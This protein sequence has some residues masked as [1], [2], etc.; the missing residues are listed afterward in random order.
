MKPQD[1]ASLHAAVFSKTARDP[2]WVGYWLAR[3]Q[4]TEDLDEDQ[5]AAKLGMT[6]DNLVLLCL[7]RTPRD[8]A[9]F[10]QDVDAICQ[11]TGVDRLVLKNLLRQEKNHLRWA[12]T[13]PPQA[14]GYLAAA[15]DAPPEPTDDQ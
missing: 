15:A 12:Q 5:L 8:G 6:M 3:H 4:Q 9:Q 2:D 14:G 11:K 10:K 13:P 1:Q 7:C